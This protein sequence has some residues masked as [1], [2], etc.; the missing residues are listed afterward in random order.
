MTVMIASSLAN[1][2]LQADPPDVLEIIIDPL[3]L[4]GP[5]PVF[6]S[7]ASSDD[8][9][10]GHVLFSAMENTVHQRF[11]FS[12]TFVEPLHPVVM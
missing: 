7:H 3:S 4:T 9:E 6:G 5:I 2:V 10:H 11:D 8:E 1:D 12:K